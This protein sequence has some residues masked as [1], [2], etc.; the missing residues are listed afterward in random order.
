MSRPSFETTAGRFAEA[1][2]HLGL[3]EDTP[4]EITLKL[5]DEEMIANLNALL[6]EAGHGDAEPVGDFETFKRRIKDHQISS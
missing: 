5:S 6:E 1:V 4:V 2:K 3:A